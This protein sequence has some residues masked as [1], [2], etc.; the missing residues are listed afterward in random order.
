VVFV[1][2]PYGHARI[3]RI[4]LS[5]ARSAP[6]VV[7]VLAGTDL[8]ALIPRPLLG[9][10]PPF[11]GEHRPPNPLLARD[12]VRFVGD[13]VVAVVAETRGQANDAVDLIEIDYEPL[14]AV[15]DPEAALAPDAPLLYEE[16][17]TNLAHRFTRTGGD[18]AAALVPPQSAAPPPRP[19]PAQT[20]RS[21]RVVSSAR[22]CCRC[23]WR[24]AARQPASIRARAS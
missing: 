5:A 14:P 19:S 23:R 22:A 6:G 16:F 15:S 12:K 17:G 1:R 9:D 18:V 2:S 13:P 8:D 20:S 7:M 4:D 11:E 3:G 21:S 10:W 24:L